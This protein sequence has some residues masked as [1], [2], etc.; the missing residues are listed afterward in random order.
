MKSSTCPATMTPWR[1]LIASLLL[2]C[3]LALFESPSL[4][5]GQ[6]LTLAQFNHTSGTSKDGAPADAWAMAQTP[7]GWLWF[8]AADA[9]YLFYGV[10]FEHVALKGFEPKQ[11]RTIPTPYPSH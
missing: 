9:L 6:T 1:P 5:I 11:P 4:S 8:G 3:I 7:D 2:S 10:Q